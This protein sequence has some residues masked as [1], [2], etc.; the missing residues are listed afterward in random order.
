MDLFAR[1]AYHRAKKIW[2]GPAKKRKGT[3]VT[4]GMDGFRR[5]RK[6]KLWK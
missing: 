6:K 5:K 2:K 1:G 4:V 3:R